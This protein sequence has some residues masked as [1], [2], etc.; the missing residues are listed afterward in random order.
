MKVFQTVVIFS[1]NI[2]EDILNNEISR[3]EMLLQSFSKTKKVRTSKLGERDT[4]YKTETGKFV[5]FTFE[6]ENIDKNYFITK[7]QENPL[8]IRYSFKY[9][10]DDNLE[11]IISEQ[12]PHPD[13]YDVLFG[14]D[15]YKNK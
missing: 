4:A 7:L 3:Y 12:A 9:A 13:A 1:D 15:N 14:L 2:T 8:V 10:L 11:P 6:A 5:V